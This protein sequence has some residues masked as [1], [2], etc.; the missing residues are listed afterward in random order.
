MKSNRM[1]LDL[2][3]KAIKAT[4]DKDYNKYVKIMKENY[5]LEHYDKEYEKNAKVVY[6][7]GDRDAPLRKLRNK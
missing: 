7:I 3:L 1:R 4:D 5:D 6:Y 2:H